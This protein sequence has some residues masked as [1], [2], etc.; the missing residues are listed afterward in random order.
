[1]INA[2]EVGLLVLGNLVGGY[3]LVTKV[4]RGAGRMLAVLVSV[5]LGGFAWGFPVIGKFILVLVVFALVGT[6]IWENRR[7]TDLAHSQ[8]I[9]EGG[10]IR[11]GLTAVEV[12][13]LFEVEPPALLTVSVTT[14]LQ[15]GI[16]EREDTSGR[17]LRVNSIYQAD[18]DTINPSERTAERKKAA[19]KHCQ[20]LAAEEEMLLELFWQNITPEAENF[21][22]RLWVEKAAQAC[23]AKLGGYDRPQ[24][25][26]YYHNY[27]A[28]RFEG[29]EK[30]FFPSDEF[31][32][33]MVLDIFA[34]TQDQS[35]LRN[36]IQKTRPAWLQADESLLDWVE[37]FSKR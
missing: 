2:W 16:L 18:R 15:K 34:Q 26:V 21:P 27:I 25:R 14:L 8:L 19:R 37:K 17:G 31:I 6:L 13:T 30:G 10:G 24:S 4:L 9:F 35:F 33:W 1:M 23:D 7:K 22:M 20:V 29:V 32:P 5:I 11:R 28:H 12:G 36:L 3:Y